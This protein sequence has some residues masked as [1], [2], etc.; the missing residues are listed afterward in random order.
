MPRLSLAAE[1]IPGADPVAVHRD[2]AVGRDRHQLDQH[3]GDRRQ[4]RGP[5]GDQH[6]VAVERMDRLGEQRDHLAQHAA[7]HLIDLARIDREAGLDQ[8]EARRAGAVHGVLEIARDPLADQIARLAALGL[9]RARRRRTRRSATMR[10]GASICASPS[11]TACSIASPIGISTRV[12]N[13]RRSCFCCSS[14]P[15]RSPP[16]SS[17]SSCAGAGQAGVAQLVGERWQ[18]HPLDHRLQDV[19]AGDLEAL[20]EVLGRPDRP[21]VLGVVGGDDQ[22]RGAAADVDGGDPQARLR[23]RSRRRR[24]PPDRRRTAAR[25]R[26]GGRTRSAGPRISG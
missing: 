1:R 26:A 12:T 15:I 16:N 25:A 14:M 3:V 24:R 6:D 2:Q 4:P 9:P 13:R 8:P 5:A 22:V 19:V 11:S 21:V 10:A 17:C 20:A 18:H 23:G 7:H